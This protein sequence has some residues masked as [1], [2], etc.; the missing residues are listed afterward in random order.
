MRSELRVSDTGGKGLQL[1]LNY[2]NVMG[3][4]LAMEDLVCHR[5]L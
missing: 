1:G 5:N 3:G 2:P 4:G